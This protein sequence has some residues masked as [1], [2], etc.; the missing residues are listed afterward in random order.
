MNV[1]LK[2]MSKSVLKQEN[3]SQQ[4]EETVSPGL[5]PQLQSAQKKAEKSMRE[6]QPG[7]TSI[8]SLKLN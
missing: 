8:N 3:E 1:S 2:V 5:N 7:Q 4:Y 6:K